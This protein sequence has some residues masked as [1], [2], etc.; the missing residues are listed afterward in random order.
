[1]AKYY[2]VKALVVLSNNPQD[3]A[4][5][6]S[7]LI[8]K[9]HVYDNLGNMYNDWGKYKEALRNHHKALVIYETF[10]GKKIDEIA[11]SYNNI[12][13]TYYYLGMLNEAQF[14]YEKSLSIRANILNGNHPFLIGTYIGL[15]QVYNAQGNKEAVQRIEHELMLAVGV[16]DHF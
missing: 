6:R 7:Y 16:I 1:M 12:G 14:Y 10:F 11:T 3:S 13:L 8:T 9:A 4:E 15:M 5:E 2:F